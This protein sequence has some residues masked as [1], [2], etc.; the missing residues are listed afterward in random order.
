MKPESARARVLRRAFIAAFLLAQLIAPA[1]YYMWREN[2][3]DERFAWRMFSPIR[4]TRCT[5][6]AY[7]DGQ[8]VSLSQQ[9]HIVWSNLIRRGRLDVADAVANRL[10]EQPNA[11]RVTL[12][13]ECNMPDGSKWRPFPT[14]RD[15]CVHPIGESLASEGS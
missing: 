6:A 4:M 1:S 3:M 2:P 15:L 8:R 10:C 14:D 9:V 5:T 7:S 11:K 12:D 13:I